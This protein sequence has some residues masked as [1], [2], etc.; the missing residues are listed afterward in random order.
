MTPLIWIILVGLVGSVPVLSV[1][2]AG[3]GRRRQRDHHRALDTLGAVSSRSADR[4]ASDRGAQ[5]SGAARHPHVRVVPSDTPEPRAATPSLSTWRSATRSPADPF[6]RPDPLE[7]ERLGRAEPA[8]D[9]ASS[10]VVRR[11]PAPRRAGGDHTGAQHPAG[12]SGTPSV[13]GTAPAGGTARADGTTPGDGPEATGPVVAAPARSTGATRRGAPAPAGPAAPPS[14]AGAASAPPPRPARSEQAP[15]DAPVTHVPVTHAA[16]PA[17]GAPRGV[18]P[19]GRAPSRTP[20][21]RAGRPAPGPGRRTLRRS[22]WTRRRGLVAAGVAVVALAG[23][24]V[25]L[26]GQGGGGSAST[27]PSRAAIAPLHHTTTPTTTPVTT[28]AVRPVRLVSS[29]GGL[30][31]YH[32]AS[33]AAVSVT[34]DQPC[35]V[36]IRRNGPTGPVTFTGV[37]TAGESHGLA[38]RSWIRVGDP[39]ALRVRVGTVTVTPPGSAGDPVDLQFT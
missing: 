20:T 7:P 33:N 14:P 21:A 23:G 39:A 6:R 9:V 26:V 13:E 27:R 36:E 4:T 30:A 38:H 32:V 8:P 18:V 35:W 37:L 3:A 10:V 15:T 28:P 11:A 22:R 29:V 2:R 1:R 34:A 5:P 25:A 12:P 17:A 19:A 31:T 16:A 24:V